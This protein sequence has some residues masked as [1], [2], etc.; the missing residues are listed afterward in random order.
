MLKNLQ[1]TTLE[2]FYQQAA[3]FTGQ[4]LPDLLPPDIHKEIGHFN[5]FDV[6]ETIKLVKRKH[7]M[8]Y[9]RRAY[10]KISLNH[11]RYKVEYADKVIHIHK[12]ALLFATPKVP[13]H[14]SAY[15]TIIEAGLKPAADSEKPPQRL[16]P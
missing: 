8:P 14:P 9:N 13:Y 7:V 4:A 3:N 15:P 2:E 12:N 10:Y 11:G 16:N 6:A 1:V 5:V